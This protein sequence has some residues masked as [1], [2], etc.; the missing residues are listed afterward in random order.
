[1]SCYQGTDNLEVMAEARNYN[2]Y[3]L[4]IVIAQADKN[5][6]IVDFGAG[7]G[8]FAERLIQG[9]FQVHC[10]EPDPVQLERIRGLGIDASPGLDDL[11]DESVDLIYS[12][13]VLEHIDDDATVLRQC[14]AKLKPGG[15]LL[16]YVPAFQILYSSMD[17]K[18]GHVRRYTRSELQRK[19]AAAGFQILSSRYVDCAGFAASLL[20]RWLGN[21]TGEINRRA[22]IAYD[23]FVFPLSR[24]ADLVFQRLFGKN[25]LLIAARQ[26]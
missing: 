25:A 22:L 16:V 8:T 2:A 3:L 12:L 6:R 15:R 14:F 20:F 7:I 9:G 21:D 10:V 11:P 4:S 26:P 17:R 13:N 5:Q 18:V 1:M 19:A 23:R 24:A